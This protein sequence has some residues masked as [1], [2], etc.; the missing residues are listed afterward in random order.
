MGDF[1][2]SMPRSEKTQ[3][4][5]AKTKMVFD[6][7]F[8]VFLLLFTGKKFVNWNIILVCCTIYTHFYIILIF[9]KL[10]NYWIHWWRKLRI[11]W[12][13]FVWNDLIIFWGEN[14]LHEFQKK[15]F[16]YILLLNFI[17]FVYPLM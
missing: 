6:P 7:G 1:L 8:V 5:S 4:L 15:C 16:L 12:I 11:F 9:L 13:D 14:N 3:I 17:Y 10:T 2:V